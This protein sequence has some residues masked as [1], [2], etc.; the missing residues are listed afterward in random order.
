MITTIKKLI[1]A[2][3]TT[4]LCFAS[5]GNV[6]AQG[7]YGS[8]LVKSAQYRNGSSRF[9]P[10]Q[11]QTR[12]M[13]RSAA[14]PGIQG[15]NQKNFLNSSSSALSQRSKPFSSVTRGPTV[16][17]YLSLSSLNSTGSDYQSIIRPQQQKQRE[18]QRQQAFAIRRQKQLNQTA[19]RAPYS[20][21]GDENSAP[22]GHAAVFQSLGSFQNTGNYFQPPSPPK[23]RRR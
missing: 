14:R 4:V 5:T 23:Q 3:L 9:A 17:P 18:N 22:T 20:R 1:A 8:S 2:V 6:W 10:S 12:L 15:I 19:A 7:G 11:I 16:S 13:N 21:T